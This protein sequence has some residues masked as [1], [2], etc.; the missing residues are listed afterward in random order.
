[1]NQQSGLFA[2]EGGYHVTADSVAL[3]GA[4]IGSTNASKSEL[5][6]NSISFENLENK[7]EYSASTMSLSGGI[8][9]GGKAES[10]PGEN[11]STTQQTASKDRS[12]SGAPTPNLTPGIILQDSDSA[13]STA[14]A[15][16]TDG[17]ITIGGQ[18]LNSAA[19]LGAHTDL[20]TA[21]SA[22]AA[23][24]DLRNVMKEQQAM[25]AAANT[26]IS[27]A[28]QYASDRELLAKKA[29]AQ[30]QENISNASSIIADAQAILDNNDS[31]PEQKNAAQAALN[32]ATQSLDSALKDLSSARATITNWG[33]IGDYTRILKAVTG[34]LVGGIAGQSA[35]QLAVNTSAPYMAQAI[36]DYFTQP[37]NENKTAQVLSHALLGGLLA[38]ANG[39]NVV[40]GGVGGAVGELAAEAIAKELYPNAYDPD[41]GFHPERL[42][43]SQVNTVVAL[44]SAVGATLGGLTGGA[45]QD[46]L[47]GATV[48]GNAA[49]NNFLKHQQWACQDFRV[50]GGLIIKQPAGRN[51]QRRG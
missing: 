30:A 13:S 12:S 28:V 27:T 5:T 17:N 48:A 26:I 15:T 10:K 33:P 49:A 4:V 18:K 14:Y 40:G 16:L 39:A 41:G 25:S 7:M 11:G 22:I 6:T 46:A 38:A 20:A 19:D 31:T 32:S 36:G 42:S 43:E 45:A 3:K 51:D 35:G 21:N 50:R 29:A 9:G 47:V 24:P 44:A 1:M 8:S 2:R 37:G 23:L 34:V